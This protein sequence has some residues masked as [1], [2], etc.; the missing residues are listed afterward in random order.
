M[1]ELVQL[2][3]LLVQEGNSIPEL[4]FDLVPGYLFVSEVSLQL[5]YLHLVLS[6]LF[7]I[8]FKLIL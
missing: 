1:N 6:V 3:V 7:L 4:T 2:L 8:A 5:S